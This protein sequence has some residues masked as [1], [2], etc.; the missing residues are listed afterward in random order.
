MG[1]MVDRVCLVTT[2]LGLLAGL[3]CDCR[4]VQKVA[5]SEQVGVADYDSAQLAKA[6]YG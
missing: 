6:Q 4:E 2:L 3:G 5:K 1:Q